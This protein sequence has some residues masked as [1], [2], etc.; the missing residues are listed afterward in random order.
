LGT[1]EVPVQRAIAENL[2]QGGVFYDIGAN[3]GFFTILA[4][5]CVGPSG[6][7]FA[8]EPEPRNAALLRRNVERNGFAQVT[9]IEKAVSSQPGCDILMLTPYCGSHALAR[10]RQ[11]VNVVDEIEVQTVQL[12]E[13]VERGQLAPP[14]LVKIDVEGSD[15]DVIRGMTRTIEKYR[16]T[17]IY[18]T[19]DAPRVFGT[20]EDVERNI[21]RLLDEQGYNIHRLEESYPEIQLYVA[22]FLARPR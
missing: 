16:P 12:D 7:V 13:L 14:S 15:Y 19:D 6:Q 3:V 5:R 8:F 20:A 11:R 22:H 2:E 9:V 17:I 18:E 21:A 4:A 1:Y 10:A